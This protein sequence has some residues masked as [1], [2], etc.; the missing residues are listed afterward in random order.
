[1]K[2]KLINS[3][4]ISLPDSLDKFCSNALW[5]RVWKQL[6]YP[7]N[8]FF[9]SAVSSIMPINTENMDLD[10][11]DDKEE[12][13]QESNH[14]MGMAMDDWNKWILSKVARKYQFTHLRLGALQRMIPYLEKYDQKVTRYAW[15]NVKTWSD[16]VACTV[17]FLRGLLTSTPVHPG[18]MDEG[19]PSVELEQLLLNYQIVS[20]DCQPG[21]CTPHSRER[22]YLVFYVHQ[23]I[24]DLG[25]LKKVLSESGLWWTLVTST[26]THQSYQQDDKRPLISR[27]EMART[28]WDMEGRRS[29]R[30][31]ASQFETQPWYKDVFAVTI[32]RNNP[33]R[34]SWWGYSRFP[35]PNQADFQSYAN[36][37]LEDMPLAEFSLH[38][39]IQ[40]HVCSPQFCD[41]TMYQ[42]L[43]VVLAEALKRSSER[44]QME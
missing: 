4:G 39:M 11:D 8:F 40:V 18:P 33:A 2:N 34:N 7:V 13:N 24:Y 25:I 17:L 6:L 23:S 43:E 41:Q 35:P 22:P 15:G 21:T 1:L 19:S 31:T 32:E 26:S 3:Q 28:N 30:F 42:T 29:F 36:M 16:F 20:I 9:I 12:H 37:Y 5:Q 10:L 27:Q 44:D 14:F 38:D